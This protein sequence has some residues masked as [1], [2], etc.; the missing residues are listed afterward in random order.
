MLQTILRKPPGSKKH[1]RLHGQTASSP[2][3]MKQVNLGLIGGGTVGGGVFAAV[4]RNGP[5]MSS[6]LGVR[7][8]ITR[9]AVRNVRRRRAVPIPRALLTADW[10][11][12]LNDPSVDLVLELMG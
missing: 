4:Q 2:L 6:R 7:L 11:E 5:L 3:L 9:V 1:C 8:R 10:Q 12:V